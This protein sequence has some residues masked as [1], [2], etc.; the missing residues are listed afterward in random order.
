[1]NEHAGILYRRAILILHAEFDGRA[2]LRRCL[3]DDIFGTSIE[4]AQTS[5]PSTMRGV[6]NGLMEPN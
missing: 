5:G 3:A 1:M 6:F 4:P 2:E